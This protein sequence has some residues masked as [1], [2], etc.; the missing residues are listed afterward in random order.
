MDVDRTLL[1]ADMVAPD[2]VEQLAAAQDPV[3][4]GHEEMQQPVF[5]GA[6]LDVAAERRDAPR[7]RIET[8]AGDLQRLIATLRRAA[9]HHG[10]DARQHLADRDRLAHAIVGTA[11]ERG[12]R[13][14]CLRR[15]GADD[16]DRD[17]RG[18][19]VATQLSRIG[20]RMAS[21]GHA[22]EQD[23]VRASL[24]R[25]SPGLAEIARARHRV[26]RMAQVA[27]QQFAGCRIVFDHQNGA[28][29]G[30]D[31]SITSHAFILERVATLEHPLPDGFA[32]GEASM[33]CSDAGDTPLRI[34]APRC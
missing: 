4:V 25:A 27:G 1:D 29:H 15:I 6:Q 23:E 11:F 17:A 26:A 24:F 12:H 9:A 8:Q 30:T 18:T 13:V 19:L 10:P 28:V 7:G 20:E 5:D 22:V 2:L 32:C 34:C 14:V 21:G 33:P 16:D 31:L 3:G